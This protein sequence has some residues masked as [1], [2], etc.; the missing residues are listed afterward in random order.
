[1]EKTRFA[2]F[3]MIFYLIF[4]AENV[5]CSIKRG[6]RLIVDEYS[7]EISL[8]SFKIGMSQNTQPAGKWGL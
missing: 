4:N 2:E 8:S 1:M 7:N 5:L 6:N 3:I